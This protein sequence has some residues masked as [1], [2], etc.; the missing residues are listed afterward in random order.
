METLESVQ[1]QGRERLNPSLTNPSWLV[2]RKRRE[3]FKNWIA[4]MDGGPFDVFDVGGRI[5]PYRSLLEGR[6][7]SYLSVDLR[8]TPL[9]NLVARGEQ[10]PFADAKFDLV[11]CSQVL[12]YVQEPS[13]VIAEIY[14]V[15]KPGGCV[16]LSAPAIFP[17]DSDL[18]TWRFL[19]QSLRILLSSFHDVE[20]AAEGSSVSGLFR[21]I[22]VFLTSLARPAFIR[23]ALQFTVIPI[24]NLVAA[25]WDSLV[26]NSNDQF[27]ANFSAFARK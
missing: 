14:R 23:K 20:V 13:V 11:I 16:L 5:Q 10:L 6:C 4:R 25:T 18:D 3:I 9:V 15:L 27:A 26:H 17:R 2:L 12:E 7:R 24:L 8:P 22:C 19:P 21:T 1:R